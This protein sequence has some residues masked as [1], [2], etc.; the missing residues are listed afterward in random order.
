MQVEVRC[1]RRPSSSGCALR[2]PTLA[3]PTMAARPQLA[4][5]RLRRLRRRAGGPAEPAVL[6]PSTRPSLQASSAG[7]TALHAM[8]RLVTEGEN[9]RAGQDI[10]QDAAVRGEPAGARR[11]LQ[12]DRLRGP[13][14]APGDVEPD[15]VRPSI[16]S[17]SS[18][19]GSPLRASGS[20]APRKRSTAILRRQ[21]S[22]FPARSRGP[23]GGPAGRPPRGRRADTAGSVT[24]PAGSLRLRRAAERRCRAPRTRRASMRSAGHPLLGRTGGTANREFSPDRRPVAEDGTRGLGSCPWQLSGRAASDS[25]RPS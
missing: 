15:V 6:V 4:L 17:R 8:L 18:P 19:T 1:P 20:P 5:R 23:V 11:R 14:R 10:Q 22:A 12:D 21:P 3:R 7:V 13:G 2:D 25:A 24:R 9:T 16:P